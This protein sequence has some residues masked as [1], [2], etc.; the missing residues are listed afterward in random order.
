ME[1]RIVKVFAV[2][3]NRPE[4][5]GAGTTRIPGTRRDRISERV[6]G[7][8]ENGDDMSPCQRQ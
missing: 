6:V 1:R 3:G 8:L 5:E 7:P 4:A 2:L